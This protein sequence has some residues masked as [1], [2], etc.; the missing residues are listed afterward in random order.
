M[1]DRV[2]GS[3]SANVARLMR[4]VAGCIVLMFLTEGLADAASPA[5]GMATWNMNWLMDADTHARWSRMC[6]QYGWPVHTANL[7]ADARAA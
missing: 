7:S 1:L 5:V 4:C 2:I 6:A 3:V